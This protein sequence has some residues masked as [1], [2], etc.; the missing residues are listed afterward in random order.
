MFDSAET[1]QQWIADI[2]NLLQ[3]LRQEIE[4]NPFDM[5]N[6]NGAYQKLIEAECEIAGAM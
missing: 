4:L 1:K 2:Q 6:L 3:D 5:E